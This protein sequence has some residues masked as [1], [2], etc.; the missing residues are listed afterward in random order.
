[1]FGITP[2]SYHD[3]KGIAGNIIPAIATTYVCIPPSCLQ[4]YDTHIHICIYIPYVVWLSY[5]RNAIVAG[6]QVVQA[7]QYITRRVP[8]TSS[9][10][11]EGGG[12]HRGAASRYEPIRPELFPHT[13]CLR[14]PTRKGY[15][16][17]PTRPEEP[18]PGCYVCNTAQLLLTVIFL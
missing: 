8:A 1:M 15:F 2:V 4:H 13:Y 17:Q 18:S 16:L 3:A 9:T 14:L 12:N 11:A 10:A 5:Y 6:L 7:L